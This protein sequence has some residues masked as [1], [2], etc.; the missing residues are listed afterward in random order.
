MSSYYY[1]H[2]LLYDLSKFEIF[3][4]SF[5]YSS[6]ACS[7]G[8]KIL[9]KLLST[10]ITFIKPKGRHQQSPNQVQLYLPTQRLLQEPLYRE[11][12]PQPALLQQIRDHNPRHY[13]SKNIRPSC[14]PQTQRT[15]PGSASG[16]KALR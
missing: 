11:H 5:R 12:L 7:K 13:L 14:L 4:V 1:G 2:Q 16:Q 15:L 9:Q 6:D 8:L 10:N 3:L